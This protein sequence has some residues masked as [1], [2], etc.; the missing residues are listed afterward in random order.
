MKPTCKKIN[1]RTFRTRIKTYKKHQMNV[2]IT[3]SPTL[4]KSETCPQ[5]RNDFYEALKEVITPHRKQK[6]LLMIIGGFN[7]KTSSR[8]PQY[9][10]EIEKLEK[11]LKYRNKKVWKRSQ[12]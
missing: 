3:Y 2:I 5:D 8:H 12:K 7:P 9:K 6:H 10:D 11:G 4:V 1:N